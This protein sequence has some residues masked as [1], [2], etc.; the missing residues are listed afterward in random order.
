MTC[1]CASKIERCFKS[2][3]VLNL[4]ELEDLSRGPVYVC[5]DMLVCLKCGH[6]QLTIPQ[7]EL[8]RLATL[9]DRDSKNGS[10]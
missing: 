7:A 6:A 3:M 9:P 8:E 10:R 5:Q 2:E 4:H 1:K